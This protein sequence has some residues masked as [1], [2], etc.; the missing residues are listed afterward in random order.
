MSVPYIDTDPIVRLL[1]GDDPEKR[2]AVAQLFRRVEHGELILAA[3]VSVIAD[4][5]Y[6]LSSPRIYRQSR[7]QITS[8]LVPLI[9]MPGF[10]VEQKHLVLRAFDIYLQT[11]LDFSDAIIVASMQRADAQVLY[12]YDRH[13]DRVPGIR[14]TDPGQDASG[15]NGARP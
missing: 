4:T 7:Q 8:A 6:V 12:T 11:P 14:R 15:A 2:I 9:E 1:T 10:R 5:V 3:P 13:F